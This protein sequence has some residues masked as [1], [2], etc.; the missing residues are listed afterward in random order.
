M[1]CYCYIQSEQLKRVDCIRWCKKSNSEAQCSQ[2]FPLTELHKTNWHWVTILLIKNWFHVEIDSLDVS[3]KLCIQSTRMTPVGDATTECFYIIYEL[4]K[5][6][7]QNKRILAPVVVPKIVIKLGWR[8]KLKSCIRHFQ[9]V[10]E[11]KSSSTPFTWLSCFFWHLFI[12]FP[13]PSLS[14]AR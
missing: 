9:K 6:Q 12:N 10:K 13:I 3:K 7:Q 1:L 5:C 4:T 11:C 14:F 2:Y 8:I